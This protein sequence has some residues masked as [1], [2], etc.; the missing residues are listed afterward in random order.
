MPILFCFFYQLTHT[1]LQD[2]VTI[3]LKAAPNMWQLLQSQARSTA[4]MG[5]CHCQFF[6]QFECRMVASCRC[7]CVCVE[8]L[9]GLC[10]CFCRTSG[11]SSFKS[12]A[13]GLH[14]EL[15][16]VAFLEVWPTSVIAAA[17]MATMLLKQRLPVTCN[18]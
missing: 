4:E 12:R 14:V 9:H 10:T 16:G 8:L 13:T 2:S 5:A 3:V 6:P 15:L 11:L 7:S 18:F 17:V 1:L